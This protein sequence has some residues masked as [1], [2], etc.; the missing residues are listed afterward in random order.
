MKRFV[1]AFALAVAAAAL[2]APAVSS[3]SG[4]VRHPAKKQPQVRIHENCPF[5]NSSASSAD[6]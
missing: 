2:A 1:T 6:L 5:S 3:A 4:T